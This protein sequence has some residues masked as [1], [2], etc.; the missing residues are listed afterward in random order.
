VKVDLS[1]MN[2]VTAAFEGQDAIASTVGTAGLASQSVLVDAAVAAGV[3]R[4][5]LSDFG[6][7]QGLPPCL[8]L[9]TRS[10]STRNSE[11]QLLTSRIY[12]YLSL[13]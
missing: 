8:Y 13:Q 11:K 2:S 3:K 6:C 9:G 12:M 7:Y 10:Q 4:F 5:L 1:S